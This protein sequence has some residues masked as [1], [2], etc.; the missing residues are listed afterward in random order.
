MTL[1]Q[2]RD[3]IAIVSHGGY[4]S[5]ARSLDVSQSGLTKSIAK[6]ESDYGISLLER[7]S[8]GLVLTL[9]GEVFLRYAE[10]ILLESERA[11]QWLRTSR[12]R[13]AASVALGV[14]IEPSLQLVP[15]VL[16]DFRQKF[17]DVAIRISHGVASEIITAL[18]ENRLELAVTRL[19]SDFAATD[20]KVDVIYESEPAIVTRRG[21]PHARARSLRELVKFD[22]VVVGDPLQSGAGDASIT[23]LFDEKSL[24]RPRIAAVTDSLFGA[25]A[26]LVESD[27]FSRLPRTILDHPLIGARLVA[28]DVREPPRRYRVAVV[29]KSNRQL[30]TEAQTLAAMLSSFARIRQA[31]NRDGQAAVPDSEA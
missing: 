23:E 3:L 30:S 17:P 16:G 21:N 12:N 25:I 31:M 26:M 15:A 5:A 22:W 20:L 8:K 13:H 24:G 18:R 7:T 11:E 27:C 1:Q 10:T 9:D 29:R 28:V 4:R 19:P 2:L 6:L 14:S